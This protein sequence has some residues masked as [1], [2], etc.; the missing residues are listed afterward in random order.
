M[1]YYINTFI[2]SLAM[3]PMYLLELFLATLARHAESSTWL[4][5]F[6]TAL[7]KDNVGS[8]VLARHAEK[9]IWRA[10]SFF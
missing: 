5:D 7:A 10:G 6:G 1:T 8:C 9:L 2:Q 3:L 4:H